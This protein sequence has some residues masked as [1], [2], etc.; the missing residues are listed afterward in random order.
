[1]RPLLL[2]TVVA[3]CLPLSSAGQGAPPAA[4]AGVP[5]ARSPLVPD[6]AG[7]R[8]AFVTA[9]GARLQYLDFGGNGEPVAP[10]RGRE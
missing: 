5:A 10:G 9:G 4:P 2:L 1:M 6:L 7:A 3:L 8:S